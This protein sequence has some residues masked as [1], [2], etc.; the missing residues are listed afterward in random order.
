MGGT[1]HLEMYSLPNAG[2]GQVR[3]GVR[4]A[5][6]GSEHLCGELSLLIQSLMISKRISPSDTHL[7]DVACALD[8][9]AE[10]ARTISAAAFLCVRIARPPPVPEL[11]P[12]I[13]IMASAGVALQ[14]LCIEDS[15]D[16]ASPVP[17]CPHDALQRLGRESFP[18][19]MVRI[20]HARRH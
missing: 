12:V 7:Q 19:R 20:R 13:L 10:A 2:G 3:C 5:K 17:E 11:L 9:Y 14:H 8:T 18:V 6:I 1:G 16:Y 15:T 4:T